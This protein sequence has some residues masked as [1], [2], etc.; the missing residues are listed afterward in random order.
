MGS[1]Q[2]TNWGLLIGLALMLG[3]LSCLVVL[4]KYQ[5]DPQR[6][7]TELPV[8]G[9]VA[10]FSLINQSGQSVSLADLKGRPWVADIIFTR[11]AGPCPEMT[12]KM[13]QLQDALPDGSPVVLVTLT[14]DADHDTP[15][16]LA[17][18]AARFGADPA[19]WTFL[20]GDKVAIANL[21][22]DSLKL[23]AIEKPPEERTDPNDLF[24]HSTI[25]VVVDR[26]G[27]LRGSFESVG[28]DVSW[29]DA[30]QAILNAVATL[31][32]EP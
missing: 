22:I 30:K 25:F 5:P 24:V 15:E 7:S 26:Q 31:E 18:Y 8:I 29:T 21:A 28:D 13:K 32:N 9:P 16:V 6:A 19:R 14:T 2:R 20:T 4:L 27:R 12:R 3:I 10:D 11:C 1:P 23:T 17:Q